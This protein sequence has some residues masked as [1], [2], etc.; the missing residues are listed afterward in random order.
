V[1]PAPG[2]FD[3]LL[4]E[5]RRAVEN[6]LRGGDGSP[7]SWDYPE[8][9]DKRVADAEAALREHVNNLGATN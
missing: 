5:Y 2:E 6:R 1:M 8:N 9:F 7:G 4:A 3:R